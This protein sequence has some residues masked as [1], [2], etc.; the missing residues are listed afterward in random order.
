[1][2]GKAMFHLNV[3]IHGKLEIQQMQKNDFQKT[4]NHAQIQH[5]NVR[6]ESKE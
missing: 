2:N 5:K 4:N 3:L 6:I 1:V